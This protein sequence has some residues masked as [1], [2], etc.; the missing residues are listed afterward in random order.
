MLIFI[1]RVAVQSQ[2]SG[3]V[4][5]LGFGR[6]GNLICLGRFGWSLC[7]RSNMLKSATMCMN[8]EST[9]FKEY[10]FP[11]LSQNNSRTPPSGITLANIINFVTINE[12]GIITCVSVVSKGTFE[13]GRVFRLNEGLSC[14]VKSIQVV[15]DDFRRRFSFL[16]R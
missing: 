16:S 14:F 12:D 5:L 13:F 6:Q 15:L 11:I 4:N 10:L 9:M 7:N 3:S 1:L 8:V 2:S